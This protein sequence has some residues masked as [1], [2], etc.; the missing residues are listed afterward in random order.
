MSPGMIVL[1][2]SALRA[3]IIAQTLVFLYQKKVM[4]HS[5]DGPGVTP[6]LLKNIVPFTRVRNSSPSDTPPFTNPVDPIYHNK[7]SKLS[8]IR[9]PQNGPESGAARRLSKNVENNFDT[10]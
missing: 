7:I 4:S 3:P 10:F 6:Q 1:W 9:A 2:H 8:R 5:H